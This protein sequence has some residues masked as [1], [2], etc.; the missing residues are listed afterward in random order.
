M[1][2]RRVALRVLT[3]LSATPKRLEALLDG[4]LT[5]HAQADPRD[6]ALTANLVYAVLRQRAWLDH[7]L[8]AFVRRPL[9]KLDPPAWDIL[10]LA[11]AD[12]VILATPAHAAVHAAVE[13]AKAMQAH[14]AA[15]TINASLRALAAGWRNVA[16]PEAAADPAAHL[17][18]RFSHPDWLVAELLTRWD[19]GEVEAWLTA[20]QAQPPLGLRANTLRNDRAA[21]MARLRA[22][23][24]EATAIG[25]HPLSPE[26]LVLPGYA[27]RGG[28]LPGRAE[29]WWQRQDPGAT[30][31]GRLL[32][33]GPGLRALDL[34]AG[35]GGKTG[36]LAALMAN[37][38][39]IVAVDPSAGRIQGLAENMARLGVGIVRPLAADGL[40]LDPALG[41]FDRVLVDAPCT[42]LGT[43]GRR[44]DVRWR[45][46][47][48]DPPRLAAL[49]LALATRAADLLAPGGALLYCTCTVTRAENEGVVAAL[50]AARPGLRLEWDRGAAGPAADA[51]GADG[52]FRTLPHIHGCD[53]FFAARLVKGPA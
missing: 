51:I 22:A 5:R 47:P 41:P 10:R 16:L 29:G 43:L 46:T 3:R 36:H 15:G 1:N 42:G 44:P 27:G 4:E 14:A 28:D 19:F 18:V 26:S 13:L 23:L 53:A 17:A 20:N 11:A 38:G 12:L 40:K 37:Q 30:A 39:E 9:N 32:G 8:R 31:V 35:V 50:L 21:L 24:P 45:R 52:F 34:C 2:P 48:A 49:Q 25:E 6:K 33:A 7:L